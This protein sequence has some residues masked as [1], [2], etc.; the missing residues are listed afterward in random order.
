MGELGLEDRLLADPCL[1]DAAPLP[2]PRW[3][4]G[5]EP[6]PRVH[7]TL[8]GLRTAVVTVAYR[9]QNTTRFQTDNDD[10]LPCAVILQALALRE[11][12]GFGR[13]VDIVLVHRNLLPAQVDMVAAHG[14]KV[15]EAGPLPSPALYGSEF[16]AA[17]MLKVDVAGLTEYSRLLY[18]DLD[19]VPKGPVAQ[20]LLAEYPEGLIGFPGPSTP[21]S[22]QLLVL[23]PSAAV[24]ALL[25]RLADARDF[26]V[27]RGWAGAGLLTWP[28]SDRHDA[29]SHCNASYMRHAAHIHPALGR[30][31]RCSLWPFWVRRCREQQLTSW[32]F[33]HAGSDQGVFWYAYNLSGLSDSRSLVRPTGPDGKALPLGRPYWV[34]LQGMCKPW[35]A[36]KQRLSRSKCLK[37]GAFFWHGLWRRLRAAHRLDQK[38]PTFARGYRQFVE[39]APPEARLPCFWTEACFQQHKPKWV[40]D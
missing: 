7:R 5:E 38:C 30:R 3:S 9:A 10:V 6:P 35:L 31:R 15:H 39:L 28:D 26:T 36:T 17:N 24:H 20:H 16:E 23:R 32:N 22:G 8:D 34:H 13:E 21:V 37:A 2:P 19:M 25:R 1:A 12:G 27:A 29:T 11:L 4:R 33:M 18:I 14:V 40:V